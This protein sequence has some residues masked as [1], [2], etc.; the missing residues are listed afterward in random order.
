MVAQC[1]RLI[2]YR[3]RWQLDPSSLKGRDDAMAAAENLTLITNARICDGTGTPIFDG[4][5]LIAGERIAEV[6]PADVPAPRADQI[7][8]AGK[9]ILAPGFIDVHSHSDL[10]ALAMP[11]S[12][13][14][15]T[16]GITTEIVGNCGESAFP[17]SQRLREEFARS[18]ADLGIEF[19][20]RDAHEYFDQ[21]ERARPTVNVASFVGH[22]NVRASVMGFEDR[23][24][25]ADELK[26]M[27]QEVEKAIDA[28]AWGLSTGL[29]YPPGMF[30]PTEELVELTRTAARHGGMMASHIRG[31]GD[32]LLEAA[33]EFLDIAR[34]AE[35]P[36]QFSHLKAS[37]PR[38]W[39][40]VAQ[41]IEWIEEH[42]RLGPLVRF[43]RYPYTASSTDLSSL[44][45]PWVLD[46]GRERALERLADA[47]TRQ[48][49]RHEMETDYGPEAPWDRILIASIHAEEYRHFGGHSIAEIAQAKG[50]DPLDA[51]FAMLTASELNATICSFTMSE[52]DMDLVLTH[53][54]CMV[55]TDARSLGAK[56][57]ETYVPHPRGFGA[58]PRFLQR[59]VR[60]KH[61]LSLEEAVR[62]MTSLAADTFGL[63]ERGRIAPHYFA[64]LVLFDPETVSDNS[65]FGRPP[66]LASGISH[67]FVNGVLTVA[68]GRLTG[69]RAGRVLRR[70]NS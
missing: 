62:K 24:P 5:V 3:P 69:Q 47:A 63:H 31:E 67:V 4:Q 9:R 11:E 2:S 44:L 15:I 68:E 1:L 59:F 23:P 58:F 39:G 18:Y 52:T 38:N 55:C 6:L 22:G 48:R 66:K 53:P 57:A 28:G 37:G 12:E 61:L 70:K 21:L 65:E 20:W 32:R 46:G 10:T 43:D 42:N 51:F 45:P 13:S 26:A 34:A 54:W 64:D 35:A 8:D 30:A 33:R 17:L 49:I 27:K 50:M 36:S 29:I 14:K 7:L 41:V 40:K 60:E 56:F 19:A 16:Q 25:T